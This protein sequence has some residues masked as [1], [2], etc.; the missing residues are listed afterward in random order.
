[1][2]LAT[3]LPEYLTH[4]HR[5]RTSAFSVDKL[6]GDAS[7]REYFRIRFDNGPQPRNLVAMVFEPETAFR[8]EEGMSQH[9]NVDEF[10][11]V[12]MLRYFQRC[13]LPVPE[14]YF[15][16]VQNGLI[17]LEDLGD[18]QM[19][20]LVKAADRATQKDWYCKAID[21][22][23][24]MQAATLKDD[25]KESVAYSRS[26]DHKLL[27]WEFE[28]YLEWGIEAL[29]GV[30]IDT[31]LRNEITTYFS[32]I[33]NE[34]QRLPQQLVHRDF[35]S[36]NLMVMPERLVLID[37]QD[38]LIGPRPYDLVALLR[39]SY[40]P[41]EPSLVL[42]LIDYYLQRFET[43]TGQAAA[44]SKDAFLRGFY[45]QTIQR[46]LKDAGR[47]VFIDRVKHNNWF[48]PFIPDS[49]SYVNWALKQV[50]EF[51][52]LAALLARF[53]ERLVS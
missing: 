21:L 24:S 22:L 9:G 26:F 38:A 12:N 19:Y 52:P 44:E 41:L 20:A 50:P 34:L 51:A 23:V 40:I 42:E 1:M 49:L 45:L 47:F 5:E 33:C 27:M 39:D 17:L 30:I 13:Q 25:A 10:P 35:Q 32:E 53:E 15:A 16:D 29:H 46:K 3:I 4:L 43:V 7:N 28:H 11:F 37:F 31:E 2:E 6:A 14:L 18:Q 8:S 36:R 48:L